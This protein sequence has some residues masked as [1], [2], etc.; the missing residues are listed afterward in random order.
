MSVISFAPPDRKRCY[1]I[2]SSPVTV[3]DVIDR[4]TDTELKRERERQRERERHLFLCPRGARI[5]RGI[6]EAHPSS[7]IPPTPLALSHSPFN[8]PLALATSENGLL[9]LPL[10]LLLLLLLAKRVVTPKDS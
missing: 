10:L 9:A 4:Y 8:P 3:E 7:N 5:S 1:S 6:S 2:C